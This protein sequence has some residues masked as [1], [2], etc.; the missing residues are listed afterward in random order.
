MV[1]SEVSKVTPASEVG[2]GP[3]APHS[4]PPLAAESAGE[5]M[6]EWSPGASRGAVLILEQ[7]PPG[8]QAAE[9]LA[10]IQSS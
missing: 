2:G 9:G 3:Q 5:A 6:G 8:Y 4:A 10:F 7:L 1:L